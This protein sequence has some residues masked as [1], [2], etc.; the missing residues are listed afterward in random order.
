MG[1][2]LADDTVIPGST[3]TFPKCN[4]GN[5]SFKCL[6]GIVE[7]HSDKDLDQN[8]L[9]PKS[10]VNFNEGNILFSVLNPNPEH[11]KIKKNT[12]VAT[13][14]SIMSAVDLVNN[15]ENQAH[16]DTIESECLRDYLK[17]M[18]ENV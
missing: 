13:I 17:N 1:V 2:Y 4:L 14:Q 16:T 12:Q 18:M 15:S 6:E 9:I 10:L 3:E 5:S 7:P 8:I 11:V